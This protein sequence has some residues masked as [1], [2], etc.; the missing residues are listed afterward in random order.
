MRG[1]SPVGTSRRQIITSCQAMESDRARR[2]ALLHRKP[3]SAAH[4]R[5]GDV[6]AVARAGQHRWLQAARCRA[7]HRA[8]HLRIDE[9][10]GSFVSEG[11][12]APVGTRRGGT[13][14]SGQ[15]GHG[16]ASGRGEHVA[17]QL[18]GDRRPEHVGLARARDRFDGEQRAARRRPRAPRRREL[19]EAGRQPSG[20]G[21]LS[22]L[23]GQSL[24][25]LGRGRALGRPV[26]L[27]R[28]QLGLRR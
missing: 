2:E 1:V 15:R 23:L 13:D 20:L 17:E 19:L 8:H 9:P 5:E 6:R 28:G 25:L 24:L 21:L 27:Q 12:P 3:G 7:G 14:R 22:Q 4:A 26:P 11:Q 10:D 18:N 16:P